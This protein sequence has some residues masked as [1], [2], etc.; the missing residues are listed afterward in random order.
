MVYAGHET[1]MQCIAHLRLKFAAHL[2][3]RS[4]VWQE[5]TP[6]DLTWVCTSAIGWHNHV[7]YSK[8]RHILHAGFA[9]AVRARTDDELSGSMC[10]YI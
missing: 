10:N 9:L 5:L 7:Y 4:R 1:R 3:L 8:L 2:I 6:T